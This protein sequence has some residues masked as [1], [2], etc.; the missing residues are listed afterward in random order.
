MRRSSATTTTFVVVAADGSVR[1]MSTTRDTT[2]VADCKIDWA[3]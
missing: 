3:W 2:T 1:V